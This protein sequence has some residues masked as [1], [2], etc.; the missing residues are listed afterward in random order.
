MKLRITSR[1]CKLMDIGNRNTLFGGQMLAWLDEAA[2]LYAMEITQCNDLVTYRL[3]ETVFKRPVRH[4]DILHFYGDA[5]RMGRCSLTFQLYV[6]VNDEMCLH[7]E[8]TFVR[9]DENGQKTPID[10]SKSRLVSASGTMQ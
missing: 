5:P 7:T 1:I 2:A 6:M 9:S 3:A 4:N 10:W 8:C